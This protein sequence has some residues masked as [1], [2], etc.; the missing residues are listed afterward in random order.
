MSDGKW[1]N[2]VG[3][4]GSTVSLIFIT[5]LCHFFVEPQPSQFGT[6]TVP[7]RV[8][9]ISRKK[10]KKKVK[11][12]IYFMFREVVGI[13][14]RGSWNCSNGSLKIHEGTGGSM[15]LLTFIVKLELKPRE[16]K[17]SNSIVQGCDKSLTS[18]TRCTY[19]WNCIKL[20]KKKNWLLRHNN[21]YFF[22][23]N[24]S[25]IKKIL[26]IFSILKKKFQKIDNL[27]TEPF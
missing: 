21:F 7:S 17:A 16:R 27:L 4:K 11:E 26:I 5:Q 24:F 3:Q 10:K 6:V 20:I 9:D 8:R 25:I 15:Y 1:P 23:L 12:E 19:L 2:F 22:F 18:P 14:E 13:S